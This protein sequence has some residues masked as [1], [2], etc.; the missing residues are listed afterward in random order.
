MRQKG[1]VL[2]CRMKL[3]YVIPKGFFCVLLCEACLCRGM[4]Q[5]NRP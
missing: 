4:R 5:Q 1:T 2:W 3:H